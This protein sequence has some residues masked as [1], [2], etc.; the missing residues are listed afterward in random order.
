MLDQ[1][2]SSSQMTM[3]FGFC[4]Y[5]ATAGAVTN[6]AAATTA[7]EPSTMFLILFRA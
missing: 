6:V 7:N 4:C 2:M 1:P 3:M 5:C